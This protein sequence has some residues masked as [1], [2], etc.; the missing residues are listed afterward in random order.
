MSDDGMQR[1][2][3]LVDNYVSGQN[4]KNATSMGKHT[5]GRWKYCVELA[6]LGWEAY[7]FEQVP[8]QTEEQ[9]II[10]WRKEGLEEIHLK[11]GFTDQC[12]WIQ[13]LERKHLKEKKDGIIQESEG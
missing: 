9:V 6:K 12:L 10:K 13:Y 7:A 4:K 5:I 11:M 1:V 2:Y 3:D 8:S